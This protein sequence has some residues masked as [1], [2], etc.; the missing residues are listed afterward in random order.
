MCG[1]SYVKIE[2]GL[3]TASAISIPVHFFVACNI[4]GILF[5]VSACLCL[6]NV[7]MFLEFHKYT[8]LSFAILAF[9]GHILC[10]H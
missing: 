9:I 2:W 8:P 6:V 10:T 3:I 5:L 4:S 1:K 7:L